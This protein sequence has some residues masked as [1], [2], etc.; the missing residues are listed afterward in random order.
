MNPL[1]W[2]SR[3][4]VW[5]A[6]ATSS[7]LELASRCPDID[8]I[9]RLW[10]SEI[11]RSGLSFGVA[12]FVIEGERWLRI[13]P[14]DQTDE[15][16][17]V[18]EATLSSALGGSETVRL[19]T[20][21][22]RDSETILIPYAGLN[23]WRGIA[24]LWTRRGRFR[25]SQV[26]EAQAVAAAMGRCLTAL[27]KSE[28]SR[29]QAIALERSRW[30]S[31]LHDGHLQTLLSAKLH[32]EVCASL[33]LQHH[34]FCLS[35]ETSSGAS[36]R[37]ENELARLHD[38]LHDTVREARQFLLEL[39]SPP[40]S[41]EQ[42]LPWLRSYAD[43]FTRETGVTVTVRVE[44]EGEMPQSQVEEATRL[45][46]EALTNVR[47]H[48]KAGAVR[49]VVAFSDQST[50]ISV[51]DDGVGFNVRTTMEDLLDSSHSGL[52]GIRYHTESVGGEMRLRSEIG[53][54]T[55]LH[56]RFPRGS[57]R[58]AGEE[59]RR[60]PRTPGVRVPGAVPAVPTL[61][62][63]AESRFV[64]GAPV[65]RDT[66]VR[67]SIRETLAEAITSF[68]EQETREKSGQEGDAGSGRQ[69]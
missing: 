51:S 32:A 63:A 3:R 41:A 18:T 46:R 45:I 61:P 58:I 59:R 36:T 52:I 13:L 16:P 39:R 62:A 49:I 30:A 11:A 26:R 48:A 28:L 10:A 7:A 1:G 40:V 25:R 24:A 21:V 17:A 38:L 29:Q 44:G 27:R 47:K 37:L 68:I 8:E 64:P 67:D 69:T 6:E 42:F 50:S 66:S 57:R 34:E 19:R 5:L 15:V 2:S 33:E 55:T 23:S 22:P 60:T 56:F 35:L 65:L 14:E 12:L 9:L 20:P 31:E 4:R 43:D 54:G 53:R